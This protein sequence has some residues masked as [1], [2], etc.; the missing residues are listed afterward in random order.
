[1]IRIQIIN[2]PNLNLTGKRELEIYGSASFE[3]FLDELR[4]AYKD[5][6]L[7]YVQSNVEGELVS[8]VQDAGKN[9]D[10]IILNPG[11]YTHT[12]V[13]LRDAVAAIQTPVIE[14]HISNIASRETFRHN[15][16]LSGV[17]H[18]MIMGFGLQSY[19]LA[20]RSLIP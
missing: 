17:C 4:N 12:S 2:G 18:G 9:T 6:H 5:V 16:V 7:D 19:S 13:A 20:I 15:S 8:A 11:G 1:M 3:S 14:V 10:G